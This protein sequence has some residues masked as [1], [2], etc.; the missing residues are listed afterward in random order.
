MWLHITDYFPSPEYKPLKSCSINT[1]KYSFP[2]GI[3]FSPF[4]TAL[5][6]ICQLLKRRRLYRLTEDNNQQGKDHL[7]NGDSQCDSTDVRNGHNWQFVSYLR[8]GK[9]GNCS[10]VFP[11]NL[12]R[13]SH[14]H[15]PEGNFCT[16]NQTKMHTIRAHHKK[17]DPFLLTCC[18]SRRKN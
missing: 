12:P 6:Y 8:F 5:L 18:S 17:N 3:F 4:T 11:D 16:E 13:E 2:G 14:G 1:S 15:A 9:C 7:W 10:G